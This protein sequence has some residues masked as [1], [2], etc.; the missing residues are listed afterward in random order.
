MTGISTDRVDGQMAWKQP[1]ARGRSAGTGGADGGVGGAGGAE[2][3]P[4]AERDLVQQAGIR[5][6]SCMRRDASVFQ[7]G[8]GAVG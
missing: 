1:A 6:F 5:R 8:Q 2:H 4:Q 3:A 7:R